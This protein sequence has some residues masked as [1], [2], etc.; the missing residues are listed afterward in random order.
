M[1]REK[2]WECF[3]ELHGSVGERKLETLLEK[4]TKFG[5]FR[6]LWHFPLITRVYTA[7]FYP[8]QLCTALLARGPGGQ[9][10]QGAQ[11]MVP[12]W[13]SG[14]ACLKREAMVFGL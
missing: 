14:H 3:K 7:Q 5:H 13:E 10:S 2:N 1:E 6:R 8:S 12:Y 9:E 4:W 11:D